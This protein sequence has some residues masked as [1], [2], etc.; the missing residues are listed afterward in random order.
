[1][2]YAEPTNLTTMYTMMEYANTVTEGWYTIMIPIALFSIIFLN[3]KLRQYY[4]P[5]C[6]MA[7]G[8]IT[9]IVSIFFRII[10]FLETYQLFWII[11]ITVV[12]SI[13][14]IWSKKDS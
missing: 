3:L 5:D 14:A 1:M 11:A 8:F 13:W 6:I 9:T 10:G 12:A 2:T 4:T 7:A